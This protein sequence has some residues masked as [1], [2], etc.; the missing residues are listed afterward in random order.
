MTSRK[1]VLTSQMNSVIQDDHR[2]FA[3]GTNSDNNN[4]PP[5]SSSLRRD[6]KTCAV[7]GDHAFGFNFGAIACESCKAFFRRNALRASQKCVGMYRLV[8]GQYGHLL[9]H[10]I[11][12]L[13]PT[14]IVVSG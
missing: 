6:E 2:C 1:R 10:D 7:C 3:M 11:V 13:R 4:C 9:G 14:S 12:V 8:N 5:T